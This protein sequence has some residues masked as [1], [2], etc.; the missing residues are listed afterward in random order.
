MTEKKGR[1]WAVEPAN[2]W[3]LVQ[4]RRNL[5]V[6][7]RFIGYIRL[8]SPGEA[9][10]ADHECQ[11][12]GQNRSPMSEIFVMASSAAGLEAMGCLRV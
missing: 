7:A 2:V 8:I 9:T 3:D 1:L 12:S 5:E 11:I 4:Y 10:S 6:E